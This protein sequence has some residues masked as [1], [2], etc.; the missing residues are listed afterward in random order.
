M[1]PSPALTLAPS[2]VRA[3]VCTAILA[4]AAILAWQALTVH[5]NYGDDWSGLFYTGAGIRQ[6]PAV[7]AEQIRTV[8]DGLGYDGQYYHFI[9]HDPLL[10]RGSSA[11]V[12]NPRLRWRRILVPA[13]ACAFAFGRDEHIDSMYFA[14]IAAFALLGSYWLAR[15]A[16]Q[17]GYSA[18]WGTAFLLVPA[19]LVS[20]DRM[21]TDVALA[22]LCVG[23]VLHSRSTGR[24]GVLVTVLALA[25]LARET[26]LILIAAYVL[27]QVFQ[28]KFRRAEMFSLAAVPALV[29]FGYVHTQTAADAEP[30]LSLIPLRGLLGRTLHLFPDPMTTPWLRDAAILECVALAG[31]WL[32][33]AFAVYVAVRRRFGPLECAICLFGI[34]AVALGKPDIWSGAYSFARTQTPL[35]LLLAMWGAQV[36]IWTATAPL[37]LELPRIF[38]QFEPQAKQILHGLR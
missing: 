24:D 27:A 33:L 11:Y 6:P 13:L 17:L 7:A 25:P 22:A 28:G 12:D 2:R 31:I 36:R 35:L 18:A 26:G 20:I 10:L 34:L 9:A 21:T 5:F 30:W 1:S 4:A 3:A 16:Q 37:A 15:F 29:W 8:N 38:L 23:F 14:V 19:T 32:A